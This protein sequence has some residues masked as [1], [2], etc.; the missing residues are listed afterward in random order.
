MRKLVVLTALVAL[1]LVFAHPGLAQTSEEL[2]GLRKELEGLKEGQTAIQKELQELK[3]L[4]RARP[5]PAQPQGAA[6]APG[7]GVFV[8]IE[9][10]PFKGDKNAKVTIVEF[11][12]Y[13]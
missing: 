6:A 2:K 12:D 8:N 1:T 5:A 9:G 10:A 3:T 4:L 7:G 11:S 13:Q